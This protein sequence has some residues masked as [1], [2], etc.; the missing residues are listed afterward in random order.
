[1]LALYYDHLALHNKCLLL[2]SFFNFFY[3]LS[4]LKIQS[5]KVQIHHQFLS[6]S[7]N[8]SASRMN[9]YWDKNCSLY[10]SIPI[11]QNSLTCSWFLIMSLFVSRRLM[12]RLSVQCFQKTFPNFSRKLSFTIKSS[13]S[14][15][16]FSQLLLKRICKS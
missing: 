13:S 11:W 6:S 8:V 15:K 12:M 7:I 10:L 16:R 2:I 4:S 5:H 1:M 14:F 9:C 3:F